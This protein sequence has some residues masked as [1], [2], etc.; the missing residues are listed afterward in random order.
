MAMDMKG[1]NEL[2][3]KFEGLRNI[4]K[5]K[6]LTSA[7][8]Q[9][10]DIMLQAEKSRLG[11]HNL[12]PEVVD[13]TKAKAKKGRVAYS[14]GMRGGKDFSNPNSPFFD[15]FRAN[16]FGYWGF[17][18]LKKWDKS[19]RKHPNKK[20]RRRRPIKTLYVPPKDWLG[21]AY[22]DSIDKANEAIEEA[23]KRALNDFK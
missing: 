23:L 12:F 3:D 22:A 15:A 21:E 5:N 10:A 8:K 6:I 18:T 20:W 13:V 16:W 1:L 7:V 11:Q 2:A 14:I 4:Q 17:V 9:G 19:K